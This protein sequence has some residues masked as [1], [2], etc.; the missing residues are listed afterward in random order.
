MDQYLRATPIINWTHPA[1][2]ALAHELAVGLTTP[3][4][5]AQRCFEWV[6]DQ[7]RHSYDYRLNPV[8]CTAS[9][10]LAAQTGFCYAKSHLLV[11]LCRANG[12]PAGLCYQRLSLDD[13]GTTYSLHGLVA[14]DLP[15][16]GWYRLDPRGNKPGVDAQFTPPTE[17]LA[18]AIQLPGE[19]DI[20]GIHPDPL[21][22]VV[23]ALHTYKT[24]DML[25]ENLP[26]IATD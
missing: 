1:V 12:I 24:Y 19:A 14:V 25:A 3:T 17:R 15:G 11:A 21:P 2:H 23:T 16:Y 10:V 9:E 8:T 22:A 6:R 7:V 13:E 18:F 20:P 5:I 26:D 4:A